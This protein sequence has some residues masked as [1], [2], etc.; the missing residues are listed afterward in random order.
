MAIQKD[1]IQL[2]IELAYWSNPKLKQHPYE[3]RINM[4]RYAMGLNETVD[5]DM[6][7]MNMEEFE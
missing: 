3:F 1:T 6:E 2:R 5:I 4:W 7:R